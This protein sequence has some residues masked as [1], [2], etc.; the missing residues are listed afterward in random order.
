VRDPRVQLVVFDMAGTTVRDDDAVNRC[1]R[2]ALAS[3]GVAVDMAAVN[4]VMGLP[5][6]EAIRA[7]LASAAAPQPTSAPA[8]AIHADFV[9][10]MRVHYQSDPAVA[11]IDGAV[12]VFDA[13]RAA[14]AKVALDTGFD[15]AIA[16]SVLARLGWSAGGV[17]DATVTS[18]EV[19]R[20]RPHPD[21][22]LSLMQTFGVPD[23]ARVVKVGDTPADLLSG[24][25][26]GCGWNIG[27][28][29]GTHER[30]ALEP[31]PHTHLIDD[32]RQLCGLLAI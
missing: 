24:A 27:V 8:V 7:L 32:I 2:A 20:G 6:L 28:T 18:D 31:Y 26:A 1:L 13:V 23:A 25:A 29:Y 14:G 3:G 17:V 30:S 21:M 10:R 11:A 16:D 5:K 22:I 9:D 4:R 15:R 19:T 12:E